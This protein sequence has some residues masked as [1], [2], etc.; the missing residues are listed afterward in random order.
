MNSQ[1]L[2][3]LASQR[4]AEVSREA[5]RG[6]LATADR[7]PRESVKQRAGWAL[8]KAGL[9]LTGPPSRQQHPRP[10]PAGL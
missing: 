7:E 1:L 6:R 3:Q 5:T 8:I 9:K 4:I 2:Y 10:R